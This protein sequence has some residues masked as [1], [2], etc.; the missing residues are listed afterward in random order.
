MEFRSKNNHIYLIN[1]VLVQ[2]SHHFFCLLKN[3]ATFAI[4]KA[5]SVW[6]NLA[7]EHKMSLLGAYSFILS[8]TEHKKR[9]W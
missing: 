2:K 9:L 3:T 8:V 5:L 4:R 1:H 6:A 7:Y